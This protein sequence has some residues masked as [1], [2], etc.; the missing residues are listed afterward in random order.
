[1]DKLCHPKRLSS[2][3]EQ[4]YEAHLF[5]LL[6]ILP[7]FSFCLACAGGH[8]HILEWI[9]SNVDADLA[10]S[11]ESVFFTRDAAENGRFEVLKWLKAE[12]ALCDESTCVA[13]ARSG[14]FEMLKYL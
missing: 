14:H 8:L 7:F 2:R 9:K 11:S 12:G 1:M 5:T 13:A 10:K 4:I 3:S 6:S